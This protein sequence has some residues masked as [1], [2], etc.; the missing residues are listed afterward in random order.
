MPT[1]DQRIHLYTLMMRSRAFEEMVKEQV[2]A[3]KIP[4]SWLSGKGQEGIVGALAQLRG[5]DYL[6]FT[7]RGA[8][9]FIARGS[10]PGRLLAELFG[11]ADGYCKGKGGRHIADLTHGIY[12]K[13]GTIGAHATLAVGMGIAAQIKGSDQ[14]VLSAFGDGT[15]NRGTT[16][17]SINASVVKKLP[18]IWLCENNRYAGIAG[19]AEYFPFES[20]D[21]LAAAYDMPGCSIDGNDVIEVYQQMESA[22]LHARQ[23]SG[24]SLIELNFYRLEPFAIGAPES[25]GEEELDHWTNRDP[26]LTFRQLL[27]EEGVLSR[28]ML[29]DI[30]LKIDEEMKVALGFAEASEYPAPSE[31]F[32]DLYAP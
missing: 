27:L 31:A 14:V 22:I 25:R 4:S 18:I 10:D 6:T 26:L 12:G 23:G 24:P 13:S 3:G 11:K 30:Q 2:L 17:S 32:E 9:A 16:Y 15:S 8:Y 1:D 29:E 19:G 28:P 5:D 21:K 7:H 20:M